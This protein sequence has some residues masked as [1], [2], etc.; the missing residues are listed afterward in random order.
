MISNLEIKLSELGRL[1]ARRRDGQRL[2]DEDRHVAR[3]I[4]DHLRKDFEQPGNTLEDVLRSFG[5]TIIIEQPTD[6]KPACCIH[7]D[8]ESVPR[9]RR[10]G[11]IVEFIEPNGDHVWGCHY[12]GR[13]CASEKKKAKA[14]GSKKRTME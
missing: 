9:W 4:A 8:K 14:N 5:G 11:K 6:P 10:G 3:Q 12:C 1:I 7:C 2:N 13:R